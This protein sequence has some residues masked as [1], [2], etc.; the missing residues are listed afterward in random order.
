LKDVEKI[1]IDEAACCRTTARHYSLF[2]QVS[3]KKWNALAFNRQTRRNNVAKIDFPTLHFNACLF[4]RGD[5]S[6]KAEAAPA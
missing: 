1:F 3:K 4:I 5:T 6:Q 2:V